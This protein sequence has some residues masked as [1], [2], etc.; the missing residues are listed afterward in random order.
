MSSLAK[1]VPKYLW[2]N[3]LIIHILK[4]NMGIN[5]QNKKNNNLNSKN[6]I[7]TPRLVEYHKKNL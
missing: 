6:Q 1:N 4:P 2:T 5:N 3:L 7:K